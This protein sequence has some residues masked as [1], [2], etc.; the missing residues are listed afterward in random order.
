MMLQLWWY[1]IWLCRKH[2]NLN[3]KVISTCSLRRPCIRLKVGV[4]LWS[5]TPVYS[6]KMQWIFHFPGHG[7]I[8]P[9]RWKLAK[10]ILANHPV[11]FC[12]KTTN[13]TW[14]RS[15]AASGQSGTIASSSATPDR[16]A[17]RCATAAVTSAITPWCRRSAP[18]L[19]LLMNRRKKR[20]TL[21]IQA[22]QVMAGRQ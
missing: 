8:G 14:S 5:L 2:S 3:F 21:Q 16:T 19:L 20:T 1:V 12:W 10:M 11:H 15:H 4:K 13:G 22:N 6:S 18:I 7:Q 17:S 9:L